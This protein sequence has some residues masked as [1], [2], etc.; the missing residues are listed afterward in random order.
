MHATEIC[1]AYAPAGSPSKEEP[2]KA[3]HQIQNWHTNNNGDTP[4]PLLTETEAA[5]RL[6]LSVKT[7]RAWRLRNSGPQFVRLGRAVRYVP[8][9]LDDYLR[10]S[11]VV[12]TNVVNIPSGGE[13]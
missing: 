2:A 3:S 12:T 11:T 4:T 6:R 10:T 1:P 7:L 9:H 8:S 13:R 5:E